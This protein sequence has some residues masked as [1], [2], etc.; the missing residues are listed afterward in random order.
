VETHVENVL[1]K[2]GVDSRAEI[3][4]WIARHER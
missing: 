4:A 2:L 1:N 3:A